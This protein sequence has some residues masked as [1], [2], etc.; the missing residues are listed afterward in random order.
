MMR[1]DKKRLVKIKTTASF[2][3]LI[4]IFTA[5]VPA[6]SLS[7]T[8]APRFTEN[9]IDTITST[10]AIKAPI[11]YD[12]E[13]TSGWTVYAN[14]NDINDIS[15]A[16]DGTL[17]AGT[18]SGVVRWDLSQKTYTKF[19]AENG[20]PSNNVLS[21]LAAKDG[22]I[23]IGTN[24]GEISSFDGAEW[25]KHE[26]PELSQSMGI[27]DIFQDSKGRIW[28]ATYGAGAIMFDGKTWKVNL[29]EDGL[30]SVAVN[31]LAEDTAGNLWFETHTTCCDSLDGKNVHGLYGTENG[32]KFGVTRLSKGKWSILN[33]ELGLIQNPGSINHLGTNGYDLWIAPCHEADICRYDGNNLSQYALQDT[34]KA[35]VSKIIADNE[36]NVW[37]LTYGNGVVKFDGD[38][39]IR[40]TKQ[41]GLLDDT[42]TSAA[43]GPDGTIWFGTAQGISHLT[44]EKWESL[45]ATDVKDTL[46]S[47]TTINEITFTPKGAA[48]LAITGGVAFLDGKRW[49]KFTITDGLPENDIRNIEVA[50]D[51]TIWVRSLHDILDTVSSYDG[52]QWTVHDYGEIKWFINFDH[53]G[54]FWVWSYDDDT[55]KHHDQTGWKSYPAQKF[56]FPEKMAITAG[57]DLWVLKDGSEGP[58]EKL[59]VLHFNGKEWLMAYEIHVGIMGMSA[60]PD[61]T[62]WLAQNQTDGVEFIQGKNDSWQAKT[63]LQNVNFVEDMAF[64]QEGVLWVVAGSTGKNQNEIWYFKNDQ[65]TRFSLP[66]NVNPLS[67]HFSPDASIW[68]ITRNELIRYHS[69]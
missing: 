2:I 63:I 59:G 9:P 65:W 19:S 10:P 5:C 26:F 46:P 62:I 32:I 3:L 13:F 30:A 55:I 64:D 52:T 22:T 56:W 11:S 8:I 37:F 54:S 27:N 31:G 7:S 43:V 38:N 69:Q 23:W 67:I 15:F 14:L 18:I 53:D 21:I 57:S 29:I 61:G 20:L 39:W 24:Q 58:D 33:A 50:A 51:G 36:H 68:F 66:D 41:A 48:W 34:V 25:K 60:A 16:P 28:F 42:V 17:W 49:K 47:K 45:L 44:D 6:T 35:N 12:A 1:I 4:I 40:Y